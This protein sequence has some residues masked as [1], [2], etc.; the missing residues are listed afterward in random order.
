MMASAQA[1]RSRTWTVVGA[2]LLRL[3][4]WL[5]AGDAVGSKSRTRLHEEQ[6]AALGVDL[7]LGRVAVAAAAAP[8]LRRWMESRAGTVSVGAWRAAAAVGCNGEYGQARSGARRERREMPSR[9][10]LAHRCS[11]CR[12][13]CWERM[14]SGPEAAPVSMRKK[15]RHRARGVIL[16]LN[17]AQSGSQRRRFGAYAWRAVRQLCPKVQGARHGR[18]AAAVRPRELGAACAALDGARLVLR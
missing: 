2:S 7:H 5:R 1:L 16:T 13:S 18:W 12:F 17:C 3:P 6:T 8:P 4:L 11:V 15:R 10:W 14:L 9:R